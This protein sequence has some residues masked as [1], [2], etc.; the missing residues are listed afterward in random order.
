M[1]KLILNIIKK[2]A[3]KQLTNIFNSIIDNNPNNSSAY[4]NRAILSIEGGSLQTALVD[5]NSAIALNSQYHHFIH[6][7][8]SA[9]YCFRGCAHA[10]EGNYEQAIRDLTEAIFQD[11]NNQ[12]AIRIKALLEQR[13]SLYSS[14]LNWLFKKKHNSYL[15]KLITEFGYIKINFPNISCASEISYYDKAIMHYE[16]Q[17]FPLA[18]KNLLLFIEGHKDNKNALH[19]LAM[20]YL[21]DCKYKQAL[22]CCNKAIE[23]D[24][25]YSSAYLAEGFAYFFQKDFVQAKL[26]LDKAIA[27]MEVE[28]SE[29]HINSSI[30]FYNRG[31]IYYR[32]QELDL[33]INDLNKSLDLYCKNIDA[34]LLRAKAYLARER[35]SSASRDVALILERE[36]NMEALSLFKYIEKKFLV[37]SSY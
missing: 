9:A 14:D 28:H 12:D 16:L 32:L 22:A 37:R 4:N 10:L 35:Y 33:C 7:Q 6:Y 25:K 19:D 18:I 31:F 23:L 21:M 15:R 3:K 36:A 8:G 17:Q 24:L 30:Q 13:K 27:L 11:H 34:L 5:M 1:Y 29:Y 2:K 20:S 26:S